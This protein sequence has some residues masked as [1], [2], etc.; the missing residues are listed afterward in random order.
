MVRFVQLQSATQILVI[1]VESVMQNLMH[2]MATDVHVITIIMAITVNMM[3]V[4]D[5]LV[6]IMGDAFA[7]PISGKKA[8]LQI[9]RSWSNPLSF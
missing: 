6:T 5:R 1:A 8:W 7:Y 3:P 2:T 4:M 9:E